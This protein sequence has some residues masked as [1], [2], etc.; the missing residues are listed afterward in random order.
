MKW[1]V[2]LVA[3]TESGHV[4]EQPLAQ[5]EREDTIT[6]ASLGLSIAERKTIVAGIQTRDGHGP[7]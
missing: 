2:T 3:E 7:G 4:R 5:I 1:T 6:P